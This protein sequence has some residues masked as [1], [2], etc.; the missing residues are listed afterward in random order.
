MLLCE[1]MICI[2]FCREYTESLDSFNSHA[3]ALNI[4]VNQLEP[5]TLKM[6]TW[7]YCLPTEV[8]FLVPAGYTFAA[9]ETSFGSANLYF[10][11]FPS[12]MALIVG[13]EQSGI[14]GGVKFPGL[15]DVH[16]P[17]HGAVKSMSVSHAASVGLFEWVRQNT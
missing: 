10:A 15:L 5:G 8:E 11:S 17:I 4:S 3:V 13:R 6:V 16:I 2:K 7:D 12:G 1:T 9:L 14:P